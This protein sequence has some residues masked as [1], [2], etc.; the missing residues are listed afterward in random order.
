MRIRTVV[1]LVALCS[2]TLLLFGCGDRPSEPAD[3]PAETTEAPD[4]TPA[5]ASEAADSTPAAT[6]PDVVATPETSDN[7]VVA[8][9]DG[10][11]VY[12]HDFEAARLTLLNQYLEMYTMFGM[13]IEALLAGGEGR[14]FQLSL[15]SEALRR[16]IA[17]DLIREEASRRGLRPSDEAVEAEFQVQYADFLEQQ[18]WDEAEFLTY[19]EEQGST[20]ETFK[21]SGIDSVEWQLTVDAVREDVAG[22]VEPTDD[23]LAT[24]FADHAADYA[25]EEEVR[26]SHI[27][28]GTSDMDLQ[29]YLGEHQSE[30]GTEAEPAELEDVRDELVADIRAEAEQVL[31][32]IDGGAEFAELAIEHSTGPTGPDG[33]D[34]GWFGRGMMVPEFEEAAF[35]LSIGETSGIVETQYGFHI[36]LLTERKDAYSP[37]LED[38]IDQVRVDVVE[39]TQNERLQAWFDEVYAAAEFEILLPLVDA[40]WGQ[41]ENVDLS[42][43][44][45]EAI[46]DAGSIDDPYLPYIIAT[47]Y[48]TK[49]YDARM[50]L[51][52]LEADD[53]DTPE[54]EAVEAQIAEY[55]TAALAEYRLAQ[56]SVPDDAS[57]QT[58]IDD[59]EGQIAEAS[60]EDEGTEPGEDS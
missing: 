17:T 9:V 37:G 55:L 19:L 29:T 13:S 23:E 34:L 53:A 40:L 1:L 45:L 38:V 15:E 44:K 58:K 31:A 33:G 28:F 22:P 43:E 60:S 18:G 20:F 56:A 25:I 10:R 11:P 16:V 42:I 12:R 24:Y 46:R 35:A 14:L 57:I 30:Y 7:E 54:I 48:E 5:A 36:I 52:S 47:M 3:T 8:T 50:E 6:E 4:A 49:L 27:L 59:L 21:E 32:E 41:Q 39:Q 2:L 26:A 51:A